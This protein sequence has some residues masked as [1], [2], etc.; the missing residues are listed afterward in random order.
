M[1]EGTSTNPTVKS[2]NCLGT[3][4]RSTSHYVLS[5][6]SSSWILAWTNNSPCPTVGPPLERMITMCLTGSWCSVSVSGLSL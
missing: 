3:P 1:G 5:M 2:L 6:T 4:L